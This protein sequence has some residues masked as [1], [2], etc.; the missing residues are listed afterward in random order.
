VNKKRAIRNLKRRIAA[1]EATHVDPTAQPDIPTHPLDI[2]GMWRERVDD[3]QHGY[4]DDCWN[5]HGY[6]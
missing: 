5:H 2:P 4:E 3:Y 6:L 1:L